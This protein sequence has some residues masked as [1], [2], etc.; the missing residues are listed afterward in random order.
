MN[1]DMLAI[2]LLMVGLALLAMEVFIPSGG[3]IAFL[4][5]LGFAGS[6]WFAWK[7]WWITAP[8]LWWAY[9]ASIVVLIPVVTISAFY[10][11]PRTRLGKKYLLEARS[12][13]EVTPYAAEEDRLSKMI[14]QTARTL[15]PL[16]PGG[17]VA[18]NGERLH[19][20][21]EGMMLEADRQV[22]IVAVKGNRLLVRQEPAVSPGGESTPLPSDDGREP[23]LDF[24]AS[25]S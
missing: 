10:V 13:D 21:S 5:V 12:L 19:C 3:I 23:P 25:Q 8:T 7:A 2:L 11:F 20:E 9:I 14:G 17:L 6:I 24:D 16:N 1:P 18:I 4:S 15:T 22:V